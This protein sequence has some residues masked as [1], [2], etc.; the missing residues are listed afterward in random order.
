[1]LTQAPRP[2]LEEF[3][4]PERILRAAVKHEGV[5]YVGPTH[6]WILCDL[7]DCG[8]LRETPTMD[9]VGRHADGFYTSHGRYVSRAKAHK[10]ALRAEQIEDD[11]SHSLEAITFN[12][13]LARS[14]KPRASTALTKL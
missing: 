9:F 12:E 8:F 4:R 3:S 1:M 6:A 13:Q 7:A 10:I 5:I 11:G 2:T 14:R